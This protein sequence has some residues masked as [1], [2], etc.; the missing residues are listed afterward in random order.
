M[1]WRAWSASHHFSCAWLKPTPVVPTALRRSR[2][3]TPALTSS[4]RKR[5]PSI[6]GRQWINREGCGV[7]DARI[8]GHDGGEEAHATHQHPLRRP[9][10]RGG[11]EEDRC[12]R[13][14]RKTD[15]G[16]RLV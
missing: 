6:P 11:C 16:W 2:E 7:L 5:G 1:V 13:S 12:R 15:R 10:V 8:R 9:P 14:A 3:I 4:P